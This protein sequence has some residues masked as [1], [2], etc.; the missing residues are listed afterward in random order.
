[1]GNI[2]GTPL[3]RRED[4]RLITG[5]GKFTDDIQLQGMLYASMLRSPHAHA[6]ITSIDTSEAT[7]ADGVVAVYTGEDL[8]GKME[9]LPT[10]WLPPDSNMQTPAHPAIA[11][12]K[13]RYVGDAVAMV[14][15]ESRYAAR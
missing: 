10:A 7:K 9:P 14:V 15:A 8:E 2:F 1:M 6:N 5:T 13:V 3:K 12:D 11:K 4:P